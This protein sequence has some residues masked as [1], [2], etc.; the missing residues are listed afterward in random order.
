MIETCDALR[1]VV[2]ER[3][4]VPDQRVLPEIRGPL[5]ILDLTDAADP[6]GAAKTW[7]VTR[8]QRLFA[9]G[10][11]LFDS[12][13]LRL[14]EQQFAWY[15]NEH[16]LIADGWSSFVIFHQLADA[17]QASLD[18][19]LDALPA[20]PSFCDFIGTERQ[21]RETP[22][23]QKARHY[24][25][26]KLGNAPPPIFR[27]NRVTPA[28]ATRRLRI[29]R[30]LGAARSQHV[31]EIC[32]GPTFAGAFQNLGLFS[33]FTSLL[34]AGLFHGHGAR[35]IAIGIPASART[36]RRLEATAG[37]C[38]HMVVEH[39]A[40][41]GDDTLLELA[42]KVR[43]EMVEVMRQQQYVVSTLPPRPLFDV[44]V[45]FC[46]GKSGTF[47]GAAVQT[48]VID[49]GYQ[50]DSQE[51][52]A[53]Q[54]RDYDD[55]GCFVLDFDFRLD[56]FDEPERGRLIRHIFGLLDAFLANPEQ[57]VRDLCPTAPEDIDEEQDSD[58]STTNDPV[59][60]LEPVA[61]STIATYTAP[62]SKTEEALVRLWREALDMERIGVHD[63]FFDLG[64][65]SLPAVR[66]FARIEEELG[67]NLPIS[68]LLQGPTI[69][70]L[71]AVI[72]RGGEAVRWP[73]LVPMQP[74]AGAALFCVH[75]VRGD[76]LRFHDLTRHL[77]PSRP[78]YSLRARGLDGQQAPHE[79]IAEMAADYA[80]EITA[81]QPQGPYYLV[82]YSFGG[83]VAYEIA[84]VLT[85]QGREVGLV[86]L[87]DTRRHLTRQLILLNLLML[88]LRQKAK[89]LRLILRGK[90][91]DWRLGVGRRT[92]ASAAEEDDLSSRPR[93]MDRVW[94]ASLRAASRYEPTPYEGRVTLF[95]AKELLA[96][97]VLKL[98]NYPWEKL[99]LSGFE[100]EELPCDHANILIE[101][102][103]HFLAAR[104]KAKLDQIGGPSTSAARP[105]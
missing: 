99:A 103:V 15:L 10:Q 98:V 25:Q 33:L 60:S 55:T 93:R 2:E 3:S 90:M 21:F 66:M 95:Q 30:A 56:A 9:P 43:G 41:A 13:L 31:R 82:G 7:V 28:L 42:R 53:F 89:Y 76:I 84:R 65:R 29:S 44:V 102:E 27:A 45:N 34:L 39:F 12:V 97:A 20:P 91:N 16:R 48:E 71:A 104:L 5:E 32:A 88:P 94:R 8:S 85:R 92:P 23:Y 51:K 73:S 83:L 4:G 11:P 86:G 52:L 78:I 61:A 36:S 67:I 54:V 40:V 14:A 62:R 17:Y 58:N 22:K 81:A 1:T 63:D 87:I 96:P 47:L 100:V 101:P 46:H 59:Q 74:G 69:A 26:Q 77:G 6:V 24:W 72:E 19:T 79:S 57:R 37:L 49:S 68:T 70:Q 75:G 18:G 80:A 64:G 35:R 50:D 38:T 105:E